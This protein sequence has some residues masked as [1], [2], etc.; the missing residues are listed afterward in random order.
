MLS[1][2]T[3]M[4][5]LRVPEP[6]RSAQFVYEPTMDGPPYKMSVREPD[7]ASRDSGRHSVCRTRPR[8]AA[9][10]IDTDRQ[11]RDPLRYTY[12]YSVGR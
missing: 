11:I 4:R 12:P 8:T 2:L 1:R 9:G 10:Y 5:L 6:F 3:P 7:H